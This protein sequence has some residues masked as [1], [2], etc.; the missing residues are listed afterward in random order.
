MNQIDICKAII[1]HADEDAT[2]YQEVPISLN[3]LSV[4]IDIVAVKPV[5]MIE[6]T[7][8]D[9]H[10]TARV[11]GQA[12]RWI[13]HA[14]EIWIACEQPQTSRKIHGER[15]ELL[16]DHGIGLIHVTESLIFPVTQATRHGR[17]DDLIADAVCPRQ[18]DSIAGSA[19]VE[20]EKADKWDAVRRLLENAPQEG[21]EAKEIERELNWS[22]VDRIEFLNQ[23][24]KGKLRQIGCMRW[25]VPYRFFLEGSKA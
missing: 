6:V 21:M 19:G 23:A 14:N 20:R 16:S 4:S 17:R 10:L 8:A 2:V 9:Q 18:T 24:S 7:E 15:T 1:R 5:E 13:G 25:A 22:Y 12:L 3:R 11:V